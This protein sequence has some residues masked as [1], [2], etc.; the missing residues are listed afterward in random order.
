[1]H[2]HKYTKWVDIKLAIGIRFLRWLNPFDPLKK[3]SDIKRF[4]N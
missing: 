1:M 4:D 3:F 2:I